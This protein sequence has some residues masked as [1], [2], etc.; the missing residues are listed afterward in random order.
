MKWKFALWG[1][2]IGMFMATSQ[3]EFYGLRDVVDFAFL[4]GGGLP[5]ALIGLIIGYAV[6]KFT[7]R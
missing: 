7:K 1:Q 4:V 6:E 2:V 3:Q 5:I